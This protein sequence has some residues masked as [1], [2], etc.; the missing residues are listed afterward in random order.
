MPKEKPHINVVVIG[1]V[2]SGKSTTMGHMIYKCGGIDKRM[3]EKYEKDATAKGKA[4]FK[5][6]W[7]LD[8]L[9]AERERGITIDISLWKIA[10]EKREF[11]IIDAPG[12]R[13][14][15]KNMITGTSQA[16][17]ALLVVSAAK[18]EF[19]AGISAEGQTR[20]HV[21]LAFTLGV[22]QIIVIVNKMDCDTVK[23][24]E[25]RYREIKKEI[26]EN[27]SKVGYHPDKINF[28]PISGWLGD[29][30]V[31]KSENLKWYE[32]PT[33]ME[34]LDSI[35]PPKRPTD[36]PLR[37]A[38]QDVYKIEGVGTVPAGKVE[39]G[40]IKKGMTVT[41]APSGVTSEVRSIEMHHQ[42][43]EEAEAGSN[44]G[45]NVRSISTKDIKRG[46][47]CGDSKNDPP[48]AVTSFEAQIIVLKHPG[49][50]VPGYTPVIDCHASHVACKFD[51]LIALVNK[52]NNSVLEE[53]PKYLK[54]GDSAIVKMVPTLPMCVEAFNQYPSL[55]RFAVRDMK[56]TVAVGIIKRVE[57]E[58][59]AAKK[60]GKAA[61]K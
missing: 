40:V 22:K 60:V 61:K 28:V 35:A 23:W 49:Q 4:S 34:A 3:I 47:V 27:L 2:D 41:F 1:H 55:G 48:K 29:N 25:G 5:F 16:D 21:L 11:T 58:D 46:H 37:I 20:E 39:T 12:H 24:N 26:S 56:S 6:A 45:F 36:K 19:E 32:G 15:I 17:V 10:T 54:T 42:D 50:I 38:I 53:N 51:K 33:L 7:V 13:D 8:K 30:M 44:I 52:R 9:T 59:L 14:F 18:G 43:M 31:D 57:K